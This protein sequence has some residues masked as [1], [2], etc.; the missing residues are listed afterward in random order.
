VLYA[1]K[2]LDFYKTYGEGNG[3]AP[4]HRALAIAA[5]LAP[6]PDWV[7]VDGHMAES[8]R[9]AQQRGERPHLAI[10]LL[11]EAGLLRNRQEYARAG[12]RLAE[13]RRLFAD[14][15]MQWWVEHGE[16]DT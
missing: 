14:M 5:A 15:G 8:R 3:E 1:N 12:E 11:R 10:T 6:Q 4:A 9:A 13:A 7:V 2:A 16:V